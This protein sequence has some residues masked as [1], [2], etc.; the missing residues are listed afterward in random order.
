MSTEPIYITRLKQLLKAERISNK[1]FAFKCD[2]SPMTL[3]RI[4]NNKIPLS[5]KMLE[6]FATQLYVSPEYILG[7]TDMFY[8][9]TDEISSQFTL[10]QENYV[11]DNLFYILAVLGTHITEIIVIDNQTYHR[12]PN[13][14][15]YRDECVNPDDVLTPFDEYNIEYFVN[16]SPNE[17]KHYFELRQYNKPI[18]S[19]TPEEFDSHVDG[20][21]NII[22]IHHNSM[23]KSTAEPYIKFQPSRLEKVI[24][25]HNRSLKNGI[26]QEESE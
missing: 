19:M 2:I 26:N 9:E 22:A 12:T 15:F 8:N 10:E 16:Q 1:D 5:E 7:K 6:K 13:G 11:R 23:F 24:D 25:I 3:S 17:V 4:L 20:I 18:I 21:L 14:S